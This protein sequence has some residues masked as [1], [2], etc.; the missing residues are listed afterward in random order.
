M[1]T[2]AARKSGAEI[3]A[4][5]FPAAQRLWEQPAPKGSAM[6]LTAYRLNG[7]VFILQEFTDHRA[8]S[9][10]VYAQVSDSNEIEKTLIDLEAILSGVPAECR[11]KRCDYFTHYLAYGPADL[12]HEGFHE[13]TRK[14]IDAQKRVMQWMEE[15]PTGEPPKA[16]TDIAERWEVRVRA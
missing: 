8:G 15:H 5:R 3:I 13:A 10:D 14:C 11:T 1:T 4:E 2:A 12:T 7:R 16:L 9:W 6:T